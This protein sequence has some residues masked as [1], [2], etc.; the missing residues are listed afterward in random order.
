MWISGCKCEDVNV[1]LQSLDWKYVDY[2]QINDPMKG[3]GIF[4]Q[5]K[6]V[7]K[8]RIDNE[9]KDSTEKKGART[10]MSWGTRGG[11]TWE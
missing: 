8:V 4:G 6:R 2:A 3:N 10:L 9:I 7:G 5:S 1:A 11:N